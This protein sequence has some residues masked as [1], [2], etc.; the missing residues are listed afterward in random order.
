MK[1]LK[2]MAGNISSNKLLCPYHDQHHLELFYRFKG[3]GYVRGHDYELSCRYP[4]VF[5]ID[6]DL[7]ST[8]YNL[9][10]S[11]KWGCMLAKPLSG[12]KREEGDRADFPVDK[13]STDDRTALI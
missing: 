12:I 6:C 4:V 11:V 8:V 7:C 2:I 13:G 1:R 9:H 10:K 3:M 5:S